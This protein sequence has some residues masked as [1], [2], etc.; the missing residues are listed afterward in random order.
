METWRA[1]TSLQCFL[2]RVDAHAWMLPPLSH[3]LWETHT[4][5]GHTAHAQP[6]PILRELTQ[7]L[8]FMA[9]ELLAWQKGPTILST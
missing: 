5:S 6:L 9:L 2:Y 3:A 7:G 4:F 1:R 8:S